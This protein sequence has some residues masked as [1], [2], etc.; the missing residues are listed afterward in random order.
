VKERRMVDRGMPSAAAYMYAAIRALLRGLASKPE[1]RK[2]SGAYVSSLI[3][4]ELNRF[5]TLPDN[6]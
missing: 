3:E 1:F 2:V 4:V 5:E 6:G